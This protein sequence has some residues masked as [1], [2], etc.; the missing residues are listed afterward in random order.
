[1]G[2][3]VEDYISN[4]GSLAALRN[5]FRDFEFRLVM[6]LLVCVNHARHPEEDIDDTSFAASASS[7]VFIGSSSK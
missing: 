3:S 6:G 1:M 4:L 7:S 2:I 5:S